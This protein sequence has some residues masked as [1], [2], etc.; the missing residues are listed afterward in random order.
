MKLP[1]L[2]AAGIG[3]FVCL[4]SCNPQYESPPSGETQA[5][6]PVYKSDVEKS[7]ITVSDARSTTNAGKIYAWG[8]Y[9]FQNDQNKGIHVIDNSDRL[10]PQKIAFLNIPFNTEFAVKGSFIYANNG[11]DLVVVD[12]HDVKHPVV[13]KR[14][15]D[16][17]PYV[18]QK[19]PP[20]PGYFVCPDPEKGMVIDWELQ[21]VKSPN[22]K[23]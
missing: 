12:I 6:V 2:T 16:A 14:M 18:E 9:I 3:L 21:M 10:H 5:Y 1:L 11:N 15:E 17:F 22:C 19:Y 7:E 4:N 23:R 8:N 20:Q 13:V